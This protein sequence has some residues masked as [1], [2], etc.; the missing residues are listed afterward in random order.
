MYVSTTTSNSGCGAESSPSTWNSCNLYK[1]GTIA[2][3]TIVALMP[4]QMVVFFIWPPPT[5]V[6]GWFTLFEENAIVGL[7]DMDL[8]LIIDY[9]LLVMIFVALSYSDEQVNLSLLLL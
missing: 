7:L 3:L 9:V 6:A 1:V 4:L 2:A 5:T 8:L